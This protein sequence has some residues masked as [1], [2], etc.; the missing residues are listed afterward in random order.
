[1]TYYIKK[2]VMHLFWSKQSISWDLLV[3]QDFRKDGNK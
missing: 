3:K 1:M 2:R